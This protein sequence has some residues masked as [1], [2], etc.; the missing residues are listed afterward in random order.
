MAED[1]EEISDRLLPS[2]LRLGRARSRLLKVGKDVAEWLQANQPQLQRRFHADSGWTSYQLKV[3]GSP[4]KA[5]ATGVGGIC[6]DLLGALNLLVGG[7]REHDG[8]DSPARFPICTEVEDYLDSD[9]GKRRRLLS[10]LSAEDR[11][12]IDALQPY[13]RVKPT[14]DLLARLLASRDSYLSKK[15]RVTLVLAGSPEAKFEERERGTVERSETHLCDGGVI[16][17]NGLEILAYRV[18]PDPSAEVKVNINVRF[19][20]R[21]GSPELTLRELDQIRMHV[22]SIIGGF[23]SRLP[24]VSR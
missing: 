7:L 4:P 17:K 15:L 14:M 11:S 24:A 5:F 20:L 21:F 2:R 23:D 13:H 8:L 1:Y 10:D 18:W 9:S 3:R 6:E 12:R 22:E 19:D 16:A